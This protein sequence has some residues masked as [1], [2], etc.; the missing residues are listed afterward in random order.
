MFKFTKH[1]R[2][3]KR[4]EFQAVTNNSKSKIV[5]PYFV[6]LGLKSEPAND[7]PRLGVITTRKF[8]NAVKRNWFKRTV[9]EEFRHIKDQL[10]NIDLVV[11]ARKTVREV[12][13]E[14]IRV[15]LSESMKKLT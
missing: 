7:R 14:R 10:P 15:S 1:N 13:A 9:R 6:L 4:A 12:S 3:L 8:G 2:I 11:I 5:S